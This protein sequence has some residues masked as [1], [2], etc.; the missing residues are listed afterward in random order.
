M[1]HA[2]FLNK[3]RTPNQTQNYCVLH[4]KLF[5]ATVF[6]MCGTENASMQ[7]ATNY[8]CVLLW[9]HVKIKANQMPSI[10]VT[11]KGG[12]CGRQKLLPNNFQTKGYREIKKPDFLCPPWLAANN[13]SHSIQM[14]RLPKKQPSLL[15]TNKWGLSKLCVEKVMMPI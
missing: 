10:S 14:G 6:W 11:L 5:P 9:E 1:S 4:L 7:W 13:I 12:I 2:V 3:K 15:H 8:K